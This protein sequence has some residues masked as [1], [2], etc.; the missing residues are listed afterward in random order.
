MPKLALHEGSKS[1]PALV[2]GLQQRHQRAVAAVQKAV[3]QADV[4]FYSVNP[5][6]PS[7]KSESDQQCGLKGNGSNRRD[8]RR[9]CV[10]SGFGSGSRNECFGRLRR[11][12]ADST[13]FNTTPTPK[14]LRRAVPTNPGC[15]S[16]TQRRAR[17]RPPGLL[18]EETRLRTLPISDCQLAGLKIG[19]RKLTIGNVIHCLITTSTS[20]N[21]P[22]TFKQRSAC[23]D[24][25]DLL[26]LALPRLPLLRRRRRV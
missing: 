9:H 11:N 13:C 7:V 8:Y 25:I 12:Y 3:Q 15:R 26:L 6:G 20:V 5:G 16:G 2:R 18:S 21:R 19:N 23:R 22:T 17:S 24:R 4:I 14:R 1:L 10:C